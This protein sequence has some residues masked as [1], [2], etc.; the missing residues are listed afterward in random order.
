MSALGI[1]NYAIMV[2]FGVLLTQS[3][4]SA[5]KFAVMHNAAFAW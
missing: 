4:Q 2:G 1:E 5:L 3:G